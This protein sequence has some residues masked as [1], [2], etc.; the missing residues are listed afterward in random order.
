MHCI[1]L[2]IDLFPVRRMA[3]SYY[4][5]THVCL[6]YAICTCICVSEYM[7]VFSLFVDLEDGSLVH[8]GVAMLCH[9]AWFF[10]LGNERGEVG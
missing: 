6:L 1:I 2:S 10:T 7:Y 5:A 9:W 8:I 4:Y 3:M